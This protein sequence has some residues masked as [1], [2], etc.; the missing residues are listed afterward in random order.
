MARKNLYP[1]SVTPG[2][3]NYDF[4]PEGWIETTFDKVLQVIQRKVDMQD[5]TEYQLVIAKR[6]RGGI[7]PRSVLK[8]KDILTKT[9]FYIRYDDFLIARRQ[10]IH[11]ACG[12]VPLELDGAIVSNEYSVLR[13]KEGLHLQYLNYFSHTVFFQQT[14]FQASV[15]VDVEKMIFKINDWLRY[16]VYLPP[17]DEQRRIAEILGEW[18]KAIALTERLI[19]AKQRR[20][21][22]LMQQLLTG[23]TR[24]GEFSGEWREVRLEEVSDL[25]F[26]NVDKKIYPEEMSVRLCNYM[27]VYSNFYITNGMAFM[28]GSAKE[29]EIEK[30]SLFKGDVIITKD[31]ETPDDIANAAVV[32]EDLENTICGYHL[33]VIRSDKKKVD[34]TFLMHYL[35]HPTVNNQFAR[36]ANGVTRFGLITTSVKHAKIRL[37]SLDEQRRIAAVLQACDTEIELLEQKVSALK[38][39]KKGLMQQLLTGKVRV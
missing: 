17:L 1:P 9:Q 28:L 30:Y 4:I 18:D 36:L 37:P 6:S 34:G 19:E 31:S 7:A 11:G 22:G 20:K 16:K 27:D 5:E 24:F 14:C 39:Q 32:A 10:I 12:V 21:K 35:H 2:I 25:F 23:K 3:P 33:A 26:S 15:G 38:R 29:R 8:G 13:V